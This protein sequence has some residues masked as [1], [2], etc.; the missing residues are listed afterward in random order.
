M[1]TWILLYRHSPTDCVG[2]RGQMES[3][4]GVAT[5]SPA[6]PIANDS[7]QRRPAPHARSGAANSPAG[8]ACRDSKLSRGK[9]TWASEAL[10]ELREQDQSTC[11]LQF[12]VANSIW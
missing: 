7:G 5:A 4:Y 3:A 2:L 6:K 1:P 11:A 8:A 10:G 12:S 9:S